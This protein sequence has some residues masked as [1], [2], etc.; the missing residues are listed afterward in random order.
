MTKK[1]VALVSVVITTYGRKNTFKRALESVLAQSYPN[2]EVIVVDDNPIGSEA[3]DY[4]EKLMRK[5]YPVRYIMNA[6][7][8]GGALSRNVGIDASSGKYVAFLDDDDTYA[9]TKIEKQMSLFANDKSEK[10]G[11]VYCYANRINSNGEMIGGYDN[12]YVGLPIY[13]HMLGC[14]A[15]TSLWL[16]SKK[17]LKAVGGFTDT[18]SKQDSTVILKMLT[19]GYTVD[20]VP[21]RLVDYYEHNGE[22]ISGTK[23]S[24]IK[25][26]NNYRNL[27]RSHYSLITP[28]QQK[29]V[30]YNFARQ[31]LTIYAINH[32]RRKAFAEYIFMVKYQPFYRRNLIAIFKIALPSQ[33]AHLLK[34]M[35][36][37]RVFASRG[38]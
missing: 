14:V 30:E 16:A 36:K 12:N 4:V 28:A 5:Y 20:R 18:P 6:K 33:Y 25:G 15:G 22:G 27:C 11:I 9:N 29:L 26:I 23:M 13:D 2:I 21:E 19:A 1:S 35:K 31:L 17:A 37:K 38:K 32:M 8:L 24:N 7:N 34:F 3:R 10:L